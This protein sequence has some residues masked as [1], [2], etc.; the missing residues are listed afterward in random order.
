MTT[1]I[2]IVKCVLYIIGFIFFIKLMSA[3]LNW[4]ERKTRP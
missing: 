2:I 1:A 3:V 4:I